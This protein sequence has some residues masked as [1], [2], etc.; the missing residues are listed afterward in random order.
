MKRNLFVL[1]HHQRDVSSVNWSML[2]RYDNLSIN[3]EH[4]VMIHLSKSSIA[5]T[6]AAI[7][8]PTNSMCHWHIWSP[9]NFVWCVRWD[10]VWLTIGWWFVWMFVSRRKLTVSVPSW[11]YSNHLP[12]PTIM[13]MRFYAFPSVWW[14]TQFVRVS[15]SGEVNQWKSTGE[16]H[17][18][19][20]RWANLPSQNDSLVDSIS[21]LHLHLSTLHHGSWKSCE[22]CITCT[23]NVRKSQSS[24]IYFERLFA[25]KSSLTPLTQVCIISSQSDSSCSRRFSSFSSVVIIETSSGYDSGS[26]S[27]KA[28]DNECCNATLLTYVWWNR[29]RHWWFEVEFACDPNWNKRRDFVFQQILS[30]PDST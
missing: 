22:T 21:I 13:S 25:W 30:R 1:G 5:S 24:L 3:P 8:C 14:H 12:W 23:S 19:C 7:D 20:I 2:N 17:P 10:G 15:V 28:I 26:E 11:S 4:L 18:N 27:K 9:R 29:F 16:H 6:H